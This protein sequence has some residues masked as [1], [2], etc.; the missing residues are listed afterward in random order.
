M[1]LCI[2]PTHSKVK[3][4]DLAANVREAAT[5]AGVDVKVIGAPG[6]IVIE[7]DESALQAVL[8][9]DGVSSFDEGMETKTT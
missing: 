3:L 6:M 7:G 8:M 2:K 5:K 4:R 1:R 9:P